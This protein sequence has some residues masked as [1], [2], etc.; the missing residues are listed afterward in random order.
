MIME[1]QIGE[2]FYYKGVKLEVVESESCR[3]CY[4][5]QT[6]KKIHIEIKFPVRSKDRYFS[7]YR[8][9]LKDCAADDHV[10]EV[11]GRCAPFWRDDRTGIN[12]KKVKES[13]K[14]RLVRFFTKSTKIK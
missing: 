14:D 12:F 2:K 11:T 13:W 4:F 10:I 3:N 7:I 6:C 5:S 9:R 8:E 1:R